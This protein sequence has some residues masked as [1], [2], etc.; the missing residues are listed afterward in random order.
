MPKLNLLQLAGSRTHRAV[1][2][3]PTALSGER[4]ISQQSR[5]TEFVSRVR[6]LGFSSPLL[7]NNARVD[8]AGGDW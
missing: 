7:G 8:L 5:I 2:V 1:V 3:S 6:S 4:Q